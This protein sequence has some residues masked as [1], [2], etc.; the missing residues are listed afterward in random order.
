ME[1]NEQIVKINN[2]TKDKEVSPY[3][4]IICPNCGQTEVGKFCPSCGQSNKDFNK[5]IKEIIG[6][7]A[8]SINFDTR[9]VNTIKPFFLKPGF[10][11][12]EYFKGRRQKYVPP[13][14][15]YMFFSIIFFFLAQYAGIKSMNSADINPA[16]SDSSMQDFSLKVNNM[17]VDSIMGNNI[18]D[19]EKFTEEIKNDSTSSE[20]TKKAVLGG[21]NILNNKESFISSF[22]KNLSYVLFFLMPVFALILAMILWKSRLLY[23]KHLIF[24]INFHS[25]IFGLSSL[26]I[27][28]SLLLPDKI[29]GYFLYILWGIPIYL[30]FGISRFYNRKLVGAFFKT[31]GASL[32]YMFVIL[33]VLVVILYFT[34]QKFA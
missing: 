1:E 13:M 5:P 30:M 22:L 33:I 9:L 14:R 34:A 2:E 29:S 24:S 7:L 27:I 31:L 23:V 28:I 17:Q 32:I 3:D 19:K 11:S 10:L 4:F 25:F 16:K 8:S 6:E 21:M 15:L 12:Q 26:A 18:F 20:G